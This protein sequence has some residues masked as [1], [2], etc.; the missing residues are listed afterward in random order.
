MR[1]TKPYRFKWFCDIHGPEPYESVW[2]RRRLF[3]THRSGSESYDW[4]W[5]CAAG[6]N[7]RVSHEIGWV[8]W[9]LGAQGVRRHKILGGA[10]AETQVVQLWVSVGLAPS[11]P[12]ASTELMHV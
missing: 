2:F 6:A 4:V 7:V 1:V 10:L 12:D 8:P 3:R 9:D 11:W 5:C